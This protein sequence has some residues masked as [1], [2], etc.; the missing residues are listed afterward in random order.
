MSIELLKDEL[1]IVI[2]LYPLVVLLASVLF[3]VASAAIFFYQS[4]FGRRG[5]E[6]SGTD[7]TQ[8]PEERAGGQEERVDGDDRAT[9]TLL[10]EEEMKATNKREE[11][12]KEDIVE[13]VKQELAP[14][15]AQLE[16]LKGSL[17]ALSK[18]GEEEADENKDAPPV[19]N[20]KSIGDL[21]GLLENIRERLA[22]LC[23]G[24]KNLPGQLQEELKRQ[25]QSEKQQKQAD[26]QRR[27]EERERKKQLESESRRETL[28]SELSRRFGQITEQ[29]DIYRIAALTKDITGA[30]QQASGDQE[31]F[32]KN[33]QQYLQ[34][35]DRAEE[36]R[37]KLN[38]FND[39]D[40]S[41]QTTLNELESEISS[42]EKSLDDLERS[43]KALWFITLLEESSRHTSLQGQVDDLKQ[44]LN[45]EDIC[46]EQGMRPQ[47][48]ELQDLD[49][50]RLIG[51]G[52]TS[53]IH[54]VL[55]R[56]YRVKDTDVV[57]KKPKVIVRLE[58]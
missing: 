21:Y 17:E 44:L 33:L 32:S 52:N 43:H 36:A 31:S 5:R 20:E 55:E 12:T 40:N 9:S 51:S 4:R 15:N 24:I 48:K 29:S 8:L 41:S 58:N 49:V 19:E 47:D 38:G 3:F 54:E 50:K 37:V 23:D 18:D 6:K 56:G 27:R 14:L 11:I 1:R 30:L 57:I 34:L 16:Q 46:V 53:V 22:E 26:L 39:L 42:L 45:L 13:A 2:T 35:V 28:H 7:D 25:K 10:P